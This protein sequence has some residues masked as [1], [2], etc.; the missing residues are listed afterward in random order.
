LFR[1]QGTSATTTY[2]PFDDRGG[3]GDRGHALIARFVIVDNAARLLAAEVARH[4][5]PLD[6]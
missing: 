2:V 5:L 4:N 1:R 6:R 3:P